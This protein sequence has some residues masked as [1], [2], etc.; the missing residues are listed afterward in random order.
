MAIHDLA[1]IPRTGIIIQLKVMPIHILVVKELRREI[2]RQR[3]Q[4]MGVAKQFIQDQEAVSFTTVIVGE[5]FMCR[6][7]KLLLFLLLLGGCASS[8]WVHRDINR[9]KYFNQDVA[10]CEMYGR[11]MT[12]GQRPPPVRDAASAGLAA[13]LMSS[14]TQSYVEQ[15]LR[16]KGYYQE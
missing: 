12:A 13:M 2:T 8:G 10:Q 1:Q 11:N 9:M 4:I 16:S 7:S 15:C 6:N 14:N 5:K 3:L